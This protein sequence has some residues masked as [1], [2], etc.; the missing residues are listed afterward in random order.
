MIKFTII[1]VSLNTKKFFLKT[2]DSIKKQ[3][4]KNYEVIIVDGKSNDGTIL[5][6]NKIKNKN[7]KSIIGKDKGIYDAMNKGVRKSLGDWVIFLNS[8]DLFYN[9]YILKK[10]SKK[11]KN[12]HEILYG[13]T[14]VKNQ[15]FNHKIK[16]KNFT[17]NTV[18]MPFCH[19]STIVK[20]NLLIKNKF[21]L[22]YKIASDFNFFIKAFNNQHFFYNM[23]I[24]VSKVK[25]NGLSDINRKEV[26]NENIKIIK[27]NNNHFSLIFKLMI[28]KNFNLLKDILKN[29]LPRSLIILI[30]KIKYKK[31]K[32]KM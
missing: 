9:K 24:I 7:I 13:D 30:L 22:K 14:V 31:Y 29:I 2:L 4:F 1:V 6:I 26:F 12:K 27:E 20:K 5:E 18:L 17:K 11:I 28:I 15:F 19:Q 8:G 25:S 10:I 32:V 16:A 23:N 21:L 3:K